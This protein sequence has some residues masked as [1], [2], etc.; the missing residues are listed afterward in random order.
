GAGLRCAGPRGGGEC[1]GG[2]ALDAAMSGPY[3]RTAP[4][5]RLAALVRR[6]AALPGATVRGLSRRRAEERGRHRVRGYPRVILPQAGPE[7]PPVPWRHPTPP[8][9]RK[10]GGAASGFHPDPVQ[11]EGSGLVELV[12]PVSI[13]QMR[14]ASPAVRRRAGWIDGRVV[15]DEAYV[16]HD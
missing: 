15:D 6:V 16:R 13:E 3:R 8:P 14:E 10:A 1:R 7:V 4:R 9:S 5:L 11:V 2:S 12:Y